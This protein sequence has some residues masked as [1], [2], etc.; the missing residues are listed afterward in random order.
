MAKS[1][2]HQKM[3]RKL[4]FVLIFAVFYVLAQFPGEFYGHGLREYTSR[5]FPR[6]KRQY[7]YYGSSYPGYYGGYG[8]QPSAAASNPNLSLGNAIRSNPGAPVSVNTGATIGGGNAI[9]SGFL[10]CASC[11]RG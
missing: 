11:S 6:F 4:F 5:N 7:P 1:P 8:S 9:A 2:S 3:I 10:L